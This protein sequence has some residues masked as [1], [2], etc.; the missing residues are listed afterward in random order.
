MGFLANEIEVIRQSD[1]TLELNNNFMVDIHLTEKSKINGPIVETKLERFEEKC[2]LKNSKIID[3]IM[4][5]LSQE[6]L[7]HI[8]NFKQQ[9]IS[10]I[11]DIRNRPK[12]VS[13]THLTLPTKA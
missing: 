10:G 5:I 11:M 3:Q 4:T 1:E 9:L 2:N 7:L 12:S 8:N 6:N 13:Y